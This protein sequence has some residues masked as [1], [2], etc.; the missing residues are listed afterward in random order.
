MKISR[1]ELFNRIGRGAAYL[2]VL[3][4]FPTVIWAK[5]NKAAFMADELQA[6]INAKY[7]GMS[8]ID[9]EQVVLDAPEIAENGAVVPIKF[10][11]SLNNIKSMSVFVEKNPLPLVASFNLGKGSS[12]NISVRIR[13]GTTSKVIVLAESD[14]KLYR[15]SQEVKVTIGGCGG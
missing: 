10:R 2:A 13:M 1:R 6:A 9:S 4:S 8:I 14:G 11:S 5:W 3:S 15:A 7:G 12:S